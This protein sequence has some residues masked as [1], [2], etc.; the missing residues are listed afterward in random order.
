M[1][2]LQA[3][4]AAVSC[5]CYTSI[6]ADSTA[7][8]TACQGNQA[9]LSTTRA[10]CI[11]NLRP[12][13]SSARMVL[14]TAGGEGMVNM[15]D[16]DEYDL[17]SSV[18]EHTQRVNAMAVCDD[19]KRLLTVGGDGAIVFRLLK[20]KMSATGLMRQIFAEAVHPLYAAC[21]IVSCTVITRYC[22]SGAFCSLVQDWRCVH[23]KLSN[24]SVSVL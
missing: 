3:H 23:N 17:M 5:L 24:H 12:L 7:E 19:H 1:V 8:D 11:T 18:T 15:W 20:G 13:K 14:V 4:D 22:C 16:T 10:A 2:D 9:V 21:L 6:V